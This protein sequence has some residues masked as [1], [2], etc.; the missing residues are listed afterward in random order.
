MDAGSAFPTDPQA[1]KAVQP[2]EASF[3]HPAV[4]AQSGAMSCSAAGDGGH[5]A[6]FAD[7]VAVEVVVVA[8]VSAER[9]GF[10]ARS[11][12]PA[13]DRRDRIE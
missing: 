11:S 6:T 8:A 1:P 9:V 3:D 4:G 13:A 2:R 7:L 5:N 10:A 12:D